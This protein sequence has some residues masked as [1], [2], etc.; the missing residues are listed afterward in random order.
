[1]TEPNAN[2]THPQ[3]PHLHFKA[4]EIV[5]AGDQ[6]RLAFF[7]QERWIPYTR[8]NE[9]T[10]DL[11]D[12]IKRDQVSRMPCRIIVGPSNN[13]KTQLGLSVKRRNKAYVD[14]DTQCPIVPVA[15]IPA[16]EGPSVREYWS[17]LL[18][19]LGISNDPEAPLVR[20][21]ARA[22]G[23]LREFNTKLIIID[24]FNNAVNGP[25]KK[26]REILSAVRY[27][28]VRTKVPVACFGT[29]QIR[30][31]MQ[32][33]SAFLNRFKTL[34]LDAWQCDREWQRLLIQ[35]EAMIPLPVRSGLASAAFA[36][37]LHRAADG[38]IGEFVELIDAMLSY[39][40]REGEQSL[41][42]AMISESGWV[43][44]R[45]RALL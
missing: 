36:K 16:M 45:E 4:G 38:C 20:N 2:G 6:E 35:M 11:E 22:L 39:A 17:E 24:E 1:M 3:Y 42:P 8:A 14:P 19:A 40:L 15:F 7:R 29:K 23:F 41:C 33:D 30:S 10:R 21:K 9:I 44:P 12:I 26:Q 43:P 5:S 31:V 13:G 37:A 27:T 34:A 28:T 25:P 18:T 32:L